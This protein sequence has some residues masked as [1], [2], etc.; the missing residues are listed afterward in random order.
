MGIYIYIGQQFRCILR[1]NC[2]ETRRDMCTN[3]KESVLKQTDEVLLVKAWDH[4]K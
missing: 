4:I 2:S 1:R 3:C